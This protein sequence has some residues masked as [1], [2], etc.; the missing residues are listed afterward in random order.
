M[1]GK[2]QLFDG[3][4]YS[5]EVSEDDGVFR[6]LA[7]C[8]ES[9]RCS[10]ICNMNG[11]LSE[12]GVNYEHASGSSRFE[13]SYWEVTPDGARCLFQRAVEMLSDPG[14]RAHIEYLCDDDRDAGEWENE[15]EDQ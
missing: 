1:S 8:K 9:R 2:K 12:L 10:S 13:G 3:E 6:I 15:Y 11:M 5:F 14:S 4:R 7:V